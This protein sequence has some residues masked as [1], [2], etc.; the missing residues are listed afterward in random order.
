MTAYTTAAPFSIP[1]FGVGTGG[2]PQIGLNYNASTRAIELHSWNGATYDVI[3]T[4]IAITNT[5]VKW[6]ITIDDYATAGCRVRVW[7]AYVNSADPQPYLMF[8]ETG[9]YGNSANLD[10]I[11]LCTPYYAADR[12][13][14]DE[15]V[16]HE[17]P[18]L[19]MRIATGTPNAAG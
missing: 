5:A 13:A 9:S 11:I 19:R 6:D 1:F 17:D 15:V 8:D 3:Q 14:F 12:L 7:Y 16:I 10:E 2:V 4:H 18:T